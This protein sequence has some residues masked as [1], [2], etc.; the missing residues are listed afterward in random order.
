MR[1]D[2]KLCVRGDGN[3]FSRAV[4]AVAGDIQR[5]GERNLLQLQAATALQEIAVPPGN[6]LKG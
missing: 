6:R 2:R 5:M 3:D 1:N 4:V